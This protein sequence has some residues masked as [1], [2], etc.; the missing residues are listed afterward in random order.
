MEK[1][2]IT[3][4]FIF[5]LDLYC[6][7]YLETLHALFRRKGNTVK[8]SKMVDSTLRS[9][10]QNIGL[11]S[12]TLLPFFNT[13]ETITI[14]WAHKFTRFHKKGCKWD[15]CSEWKKAHACYSHWS[16][17]L[18]D[19][20][21]LSNISICVSVTI[22]KG[23]VIQRSNRVVFEWWMEKSPSSNEKFHLGNIFSF[24]VMYIVHDVLIQWQNRYC[25]TFM[26]SL[27]QS[28]ENTS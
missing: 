1:A 8:N 24:A 14:L 25:L 6:I 28:E 17:S 11:N 7:W 21:Y 19:E 13:E 4:I 5:V 12:F 26:F 16:N 20:I 2:F 23:T 10:I 22:D 3:G 15:V 9:I 18:N 27:A